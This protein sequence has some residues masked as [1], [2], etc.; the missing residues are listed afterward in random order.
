MPVTSSDYVYYGGFHVFSSAV[1]VSTSTGSPVVTTSPAWPPSQTPA[2][3]PTAGNWEYAMAVRGMR[4]R[5]RTY[6]V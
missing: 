4:R 5:G 3:M 6:H 2:F 1:F